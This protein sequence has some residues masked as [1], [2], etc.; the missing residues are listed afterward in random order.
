MP[1]A[2]DLPGTGTDTEDRSGEV[3]GW[4]PQQGGSPGEPGSEQAGGVPGQ[5]GGAPP[6]DG[7]EESWEQGGAGGGADDDWAT[8]NQ[9]PGETNPAPPMPSERDKPAGGGGADGELDG[10]LEDF[11]GEILA[12]REVIRS[13]SN[14]TAG[15]GVPAGGV[16][17]LPPAGGDA[18]ADSGTSGTA[19]IPSPP[20][21]T[22]GMPSSRRQPPAPRPP[23]TVDVPDDI[24][25]A[26]DDDIIAR[27]LREA[28]QQE[29]DPELR[30]KLWD[31]YRK[32]KG[33]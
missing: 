29:T 26:R 23:G 18:S 20:G 25:P 24:P 22:V 3:A 5:P 13:R 6:G 21:G 7:G 11:D 33:I 2:S 15:T 1:G 28:A 12:E 9:L 17:N 8:S 27:Q 4:D 32:Y 10:A 30:E 31:E 19:D 14:E 16:A